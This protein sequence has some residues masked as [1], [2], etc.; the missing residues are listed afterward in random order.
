M[1]LNRKIIWDLLTAQDPGEK[2]NTP[3]KRFK[4][5]TQDQKTLEF[6]QGDVID[7]EGQQ[8]VVLAV[9]RL[10]FRQANKGEV[11]S[12]SLGK[13]KW[14][15]L[16]TGKISVETLPIRIVSCEGGQFIL[17]HDTDSNPDSK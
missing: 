5:F 17:E 13:A 8:R 12:I 9:P 15:S 14:T 3:V 6:N 4:L 7:F 2:K 11:I 1:K 10:S 16:L